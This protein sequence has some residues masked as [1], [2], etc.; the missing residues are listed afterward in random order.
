MV[1]PSEYEGKPVTEIEG[2][3]FEDCTVFISVT[4]PVSITSIGNYAFKKGTSLTGIIIPDGVT[5]IEGSTFS[6]CASLTSVTRAKV[7]RHENRI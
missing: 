2:W 7:P 6:Y 4:I 3:A 5:S 1:I